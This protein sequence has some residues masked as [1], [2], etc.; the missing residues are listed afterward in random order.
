MILHLLLK[1]LPF[2]EGS[3]ELP[4]ILLKIVAV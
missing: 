3:P 1:P 4:D 2:N